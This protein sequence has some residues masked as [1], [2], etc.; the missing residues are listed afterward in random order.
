MIQ[1]INAPISVNLVY[2]HKRKSVYPKYIHWDSKT[3]QVT[4]IGLHHT[5]HLGKTLYH[6]FSIDTPTLFFKLVM[7]TENLHWSVEEIADGEC[8]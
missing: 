7:N 2:D 5:Y 6:V 3:Y 8:N 4:K 1:K